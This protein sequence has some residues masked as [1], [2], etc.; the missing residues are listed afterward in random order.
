[1]HACTLNL[2]GLKGGV[3]L[4]Y[5]PVTIV[6]NA[7]I[8]RNNWKINTYMHALWTSFT[9]FLLLF[10]VLFFC[11]HIEV[12]WPVL[13]QWRNLESGYRWVESAR[14]GKILAHNLLCLSYDSSD[15]FYMKKMGCCTA[16]NRLNIM[17]ACIY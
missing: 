15:K 17:H 6:I 16:N 2:T 8:S 14:S 4:V 12:I 13:Y 1:V 3:A 10:F 5:I 9:S 11:F 7:N